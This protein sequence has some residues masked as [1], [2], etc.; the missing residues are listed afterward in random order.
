MFRK[1]FYF[2]KPVIRNY[3][4]MTALAFLVWMIFFDSNNFISQAGNQREL[5]DLTAQKQY[6]E[7]EIMLN[8]NMV[9]EL[10]NPSDKSAL[11]KFAREKYH[12]KRPDEDIFLI[13]RE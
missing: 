8:K 4:L 12:M 10:T 9:R 7:K 13:I 5:N 11:E 1:V 6:Y 3:Y 2:M